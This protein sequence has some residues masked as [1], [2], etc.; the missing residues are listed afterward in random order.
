MLWIIFFTVLGISKIEIIDKHLVVLVSIHLYI[1]ICTVYQIPV[2][3]GKVICLRII[4]YI[5]RSIVNVQSIFLPLAF[6]K[7]SNNKKTRDALLVLI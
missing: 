4:K 7:K 2:S 6:S 1:Y 5:L 3:M